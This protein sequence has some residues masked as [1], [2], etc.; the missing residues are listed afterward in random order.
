[1]W[2]APETAT[3]TTI[4]AAGGTRAQ[5]LRGVCQYL[6]DEHKV[7][8]KAGQ[9]NLDGFTGPHRNHRPLAPKYTDEDLTRVIGAISSYSPASQGIAPTLS[10][11]SLPG[12]GHLAPDWR[13]WV[14]GEV[15]AFF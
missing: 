15:P 3:R 12:L 8:A 5:P 10:V 6:V 4:R 2:G 1:M 13:V 9:I 14:R 11:R 7:Q